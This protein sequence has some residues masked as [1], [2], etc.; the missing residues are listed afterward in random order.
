MIASDSTVSV[1]GATNLPP[2]SILIVNVMDYIGEGSKVVSGQQ[3]VTVRKDG[4]FQAILHPLASESFRTN[5]VCYVLF[6]PNYPRQPGS[7]IKLLGA[8][9]EH[10]GSNASNPQ[11]EG[12]SRITGLVDYTI[13]R[14]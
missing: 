5:M 9:G 8:A 10:L 6:E 3:W 11:I 2:G 1:F 14:D 12:N 7:V 13:L 4:L